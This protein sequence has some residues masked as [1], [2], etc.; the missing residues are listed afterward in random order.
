MTLR[1]CRR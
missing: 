1:S